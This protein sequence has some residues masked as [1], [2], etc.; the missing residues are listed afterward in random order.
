MSHTPPQQRVCNPRRLFGKISW[1]VRSHWV[2]AWAWLSYF[3][4]WWSWGREIDLR[5][6]YSNSNI[7]WP[8]GPLLQYSSSDRHQ[9]KPGFRYFLSICGFYHQTIFLR[10]S[11]K[12]N[13]YTFILLITPHLRRE[14][15]P[16][17]ARFL[18]FKWGSPKYFY[19]AC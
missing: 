14:L 15:L 16:I 13:N 19:L 12:L 10:S 18:S 7:I 17:I 1:G 11:F 2:C 4:D 8:A 9:G 5:Q 3:C 6:S